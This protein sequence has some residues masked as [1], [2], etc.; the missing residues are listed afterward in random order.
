[1]WLL[2]RLQAPE[3]FQEGQEDVGGAIGGWVTAWQQDLH[4]ALALLYP[5]NGADDLA[6]CQNPMASHLL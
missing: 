1:M 4:T 6:A 3:E 5:K 2:L